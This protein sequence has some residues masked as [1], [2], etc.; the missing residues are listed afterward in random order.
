M[1]RTMMSVAALFGF[2]AVVLGAFGAHGIERKL[3]GSPERE[4][5]LKWWSTG[6]QYHLAHALAIGLAATVGAVAACRCFAIGIVLFSGS[7][8]AM[9][10]TGVRKLGA[11]TPLGGLAML[12]GWAWLAWSALF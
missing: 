5:R 9:T 4:Q 3:V 7:L 12:V 10:V 6:A 2:F 1:D 11:I 8:Y